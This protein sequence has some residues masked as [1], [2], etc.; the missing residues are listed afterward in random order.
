MRLLAL[1]CFRETKCPPLLSRGAALLQQRIEVKIGLQ[2]HRLLALHRTAVDNAAQ[3]LPVRL[4]IETL[5]TRD[6]LFDN[7]FGNC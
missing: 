2:V 7:H 5:D 6:T 4:V 1:R 3:L